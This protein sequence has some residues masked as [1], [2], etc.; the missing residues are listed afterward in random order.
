MGVGLGVGAGFLFFFFGGA[1]GAKE[2]TGPVF[3][4][5]HKYFPVSAQNAD[6]IVQANQTANH[7]VAAAVERAETVDIDVAATEHRSYRLQSNVDLRVGQHDTT[8]A[9]L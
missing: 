1:G 3:Y 6:G 9:V 7:V 2:K 5:Y 4:W 8:R